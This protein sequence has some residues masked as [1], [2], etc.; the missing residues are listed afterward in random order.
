MKAKNVLAGILLLGASAFASA[1]AVTVTPGDP[2]WAAEN[3]GGGSSE[4][5]GTLPR[6]GNGSLELHGDRTRFFGLGNPYSAASNL[7]SLNDVLQLTFDWAI[8]VGSVNNYHADYTPALRLHIW[9]GN[10][11]SELIWEGAYNGTYGNTTQGVFYTSGVND[12]FYRWQAGGP[13]VT[14]QGGALVNLSIFDWAAGANDAGAQWYSDTAYVSAISVGAG[15]GT[16]T[17]YFAFADNVVLNIAGNERTFNFELSQQSVPEPH[18]L[19]L[20]G[21]ALIASVGARRRRNG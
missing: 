5:T 13:G 9:D 4:I 1:A 2:N 15:S 20:V 10:Q 18:S 14:L 17:G 21:L 11:R 6:S 16:G 7:G 19:A 12:N 3:S 8:G